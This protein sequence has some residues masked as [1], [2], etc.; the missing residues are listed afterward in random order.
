MSTITEE[1]PFPE[2]ASLH[3]KAVQSVA[4]GE[5]APPRQRRAPNGRRVLATTTRNSRVHPAVMAEALRLAGGDASRISITHEGE[6]VVLNN[7]RG[8]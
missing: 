7:K 8:S 4:R 1:I 3:E 6:V 5:V 2:T